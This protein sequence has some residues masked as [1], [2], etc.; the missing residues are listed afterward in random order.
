MQFTFRVESI[1]VSY[2]YHVSSFSTQMLM[3]SIFVKIFNS[4]HPCSLASVNFELGNGGVNE[5]ICPLT[6]E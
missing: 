1:A 4:C 3:V 2:Y 5:L 6:G